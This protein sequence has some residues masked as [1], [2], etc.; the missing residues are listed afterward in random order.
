MQEHEPPPSNLG[1]LQTP[2]PAVYVHKEDVNRRSVLLYVPLLIVGCALITLFVVWSF[3]WMGMETRSAAELFTN[4][5]DGRADIRRMAAVEWAQQLAG[6]EQSTQ[7][8]AKNG[9]IT[10]RPSTVQTARFGE[11]LATYSKDAQSLDPRFLSALAVV[12]S[13]STDTKGARDTLLR[14]LGTFELESQPEIQFYVIL[15]LARLGIENTQGTEIQSL[16]ARQKSPDDG[17]RKA[18]ALALG[19]VNEE[20]LADSYKETLLNLLGDSGEEI[21]WNAALSLARHKYSESQAMISSILE[22]IKAVNSNSIAQN[23]LDLYLETIKVLGQI[24]DPLYKNALAE[25][26]ERHPNLKV[27]QASK[28]AAY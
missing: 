12:L 3:G 21:R 24:R 22:E 8:S 28:T 17:V 9:L 23:R 13:F 10:L 16:L 7:Q 14:Y 6:A 18:L 15:S 4:L 25:M 27:R 5:S 2:V 11:F 20:K 1:E 26:A 19:Q